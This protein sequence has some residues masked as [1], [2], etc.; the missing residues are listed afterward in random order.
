MIASALGVAYFVQRPVSAERPRSTSWPFLLLF[1]L[2]FVTTGIGNG[3]TFRMIP[4]IF[5]KPE[6]AGPVLGWTSAIAAYGAFPH[7]EGS[8]AQIKAGTPEYALYGFAVYYLSCLVVNWWFYASFRGTTRGTDR[9][10]PSST[11]TGCTPARW[12]SPV[13]TV[14]RA[15]SEAG[16]QASPR[17]TSA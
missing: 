13:S 16:A 14:I 4:I 11:R 7:P 3:S 17:R 1:L 10:S 15:P 6:Q 9:C 8:S 2:L 12:P 5:S